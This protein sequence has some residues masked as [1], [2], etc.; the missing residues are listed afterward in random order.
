MTSL[1]VE[2]M[3]NTVQVY[4][5][6]LSNA[7]NDT[8][9]DGKI[10]DAIADVSSGEWL[11]YLQDVDFV[12]PVGSHKSVSFDENGDGPA[13][14]AVYQLIEANGV[15]NFKEVSDIKGAISSQSTGHGIGV[16]VLD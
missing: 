7:I 6:A 9:P 15:Y 11:Q 12:S 4:A 10:C 3:I 8:C 5:M 1:G 16:L 13:L 14:F 2:D